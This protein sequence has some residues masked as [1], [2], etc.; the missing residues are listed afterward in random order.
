MR[1]GT[2]RRGLITIGVAFCLAGP[3]AAQAPRAIVGFPLRLMDLSFAADTIA[4]LHVLM[5]PSAGSKEGHD[6]EGLVWL[7]FDPDTVLEWLNS[8]A[9]ALRVPVPDARADGIQWSRPLTPL[10]RHGALA[11][12]RERKKGKLQNTHWIAVAD[13]STGWRAELTGAEAD[14]LLRLFLNLGTQSR[15]D[16]TSAAPYDETRVDSPVSVL[17][18]P[19][20]RYHGKA[21]R[22]VAQYVVGESGAADTAS[23]V[24]FLASDR[25][26]IPDAWEVLRRSRF[27]P[28][29]VRGKPVRQLVYQS[30]VWSDH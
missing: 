14:S 3:A 30:I 23:F 24:A 2:A 11:L 29:L 5:Q 17:H 7:R 13:S 27:R 21:G 12:G 28:A 9:A 20:P 22:V 10:N 19:L 15:F 16:T 18:Q 1:P 4:G 26:L 6:K 8:A 25:D